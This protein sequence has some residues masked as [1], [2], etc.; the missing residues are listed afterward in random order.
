M[1]KIFLIFLAGIFISSCQQYSESITI[2][3]NPFIRAEINGTPWSTK[4]YVSRYLG[5]IVYYEDQNDLTGDLY[6]RVS[7]TALSPSGEPDQLQLTIDVLNINNMVGEYNT[8]YTAKGGINEIQWVDK[9]TSP[10]FFPVFT[11]CNP[12]VGTSKIIISR[13]E[14]TEKLINGTFE[15]TLCERTDPNQI[16][17][18]TKGE[19]K[20]LSYKFAE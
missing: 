14:I 12:V 4:N 9:A 6:N 17:S 3:R 18:I 1:K 2:Q 8:T 7:I 16:L 20:D 13:Q 19:F 11:L 15:V 10:G 5:K